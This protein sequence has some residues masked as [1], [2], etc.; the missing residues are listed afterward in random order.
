MLLR[1]CEEEYFLELRGRNGEAKSGI[2]ITC[3]LNHR[4]VN[5]RIEYVLTTDQ[6]GKIN[7]GS[8]VHI[9]Q[10]TASVQQVQDISAEQGVWRLANDSFN[11]PSNIKITE[12][13]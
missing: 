13:D 8:L 3:N 10:V 5:K 11:Y 2:D 9:S 12:Q 6:N 7:L 4:Y 1:K